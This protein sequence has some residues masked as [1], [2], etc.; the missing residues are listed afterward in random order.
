M[1]A[2]LTKIYKKINEGTDTAIAKLKTKYPE[3]V[4]AID[5]LRHFETLRRWLELTKEVNPDLI[6]DDLEE[7]LPQLIGVPA[8]DLIKN[9]G[10]GSQQCPVL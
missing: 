1:Y 10:D 6:P 9:L 7:A 5:Q 8:M 2:L 4:D 3:K